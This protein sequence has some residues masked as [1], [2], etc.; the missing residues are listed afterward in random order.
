M[1]EAKR[2]TDEKIKGLKAPKSGQAEHADSIVPGLR[3]RIG[4]LGVKTFILRKR[5]GGKLRNITLGRYDE[6][7]FGLADARRKARVLLSDI[8][9]GKAI[10]RPK[11][12]PVHAPTIAALMPAYLAGKDHLRSYR[13]IERIAKGYIL[14]ELGDRIADAVTRGEITAFIDSIA[15]RAPTMARAVHAQLSAFYTW[16]MPRLDKMPA[17]PC[18]DAGR[19]PKAKSRDRVLSDDELAALWRV[20]MKEPAPWGAGYRLLILTGARRDEVFQADWSEFDLAKREW[21]MPEASTKNSVPVILPLSEQAIA[22]LSGIDR[23]EESPKLFPTRTK[24]K[25]EKRGPSGYSKALRR[26]RARVDHALEREPQDR[27]T[28]WITHDIRRTV[29]TGLQRLGVRLE[30]TEA[31][32]NHVSGSKGG[33]AGVYQRYDWL[34]EKR[35]ALAKW[36]QFVERIAE[37]EDPEEVIASLS[38]LK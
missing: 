36:G 5:V 12:P 32:L 19:P 22:A 33:I 1:A 30:V 7:R 24:A 9:G 28:W 8:E 14:P 20:A 34:P 27:D 17:N 23:D 4:K 18:R 35:V 11:A 3:V 31:V 25:R 38:R 10:P 15:D 6:R 29:A 2:L 26:I 21:L 16:A 13:E 37:G